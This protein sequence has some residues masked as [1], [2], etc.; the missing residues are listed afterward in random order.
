LAG[1]LALPALIG[2][3]G[4]NTSL[5]RPA[6]TMADGSVVFD[7]IQGEDPEV[8]TPTEPI[9]LDILKPNRATVP[10]DTMMRG[11]DRIASLTY[12]FQDFERTREPSSRRKFVF[13][14][15]TLG[16]V[17]EMQTWF[18]G[19]KGRLTT[20]YMPT[21]QK[22]FTVLSGLGSETLVVENID[23]TNNGFLLSGRHVIGLINAAGDITKA[24]ITEAS[25]DGDTE[26]LTL[27]VAAPTDTV[28]V[29]FLLYVRLESDTFEVIWQNAAGLA[30]IQLGMIECPAELAP[31][32]E[33]FIPG[34]PGAPPTA[35]L[36]PLDEAS[37]TATVP[38]G[39]VDVP[40]FFNI[41]LRDA[42]GQ[43]LRSNGAAVPS[44]NITGANTA[45]AT[46]T[47][48]ENG[49]FRGQYTPT[50]TG[51]DS[52]LLKVNAINIKNTPH[53]SVVGTTPV[54]VPGAMPFGFWSFSTFDESMEYLPNITCVLHNIQPGTA[55]DY[56][57]SAAA[58]GC[59]M[60]FNHPR[61][62]VKD[63]SGQFSLARFKD[64]CDDLDA[65]GTFTSHVSSG[66][67]FVHM[68]IDDMGAKH[69][70]G[71][72]PPKSIISSASAYSHSL[73]PNIK[74]MVRKAPQEL[75]GM[76]DIDY[77]ACLYTILRGNIDAYME[78]NERAARIIGCNIMGGI[79]VVNGGD[80]SSGVPGTGE[81]DSFAAMSA[82][83]IT[84]YGKRV[85]SSS[86]CKFFTMFRFHNNT[87]H[88]VTY[89][90]TIAIKNAIEDLGDFCAG[91]VR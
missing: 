78:A 34:D 65:N 74:T 56:L 15:E 22:D 24:T 3:F 43:R 37:C 30:E 33:E 85:A 91:E 51:T 44:G 83:E 38:N 7:L 18:D 52:L 26:I 14:T 13:T 59:R 42:N 12:T 20:F 81:R 5:S 72:E 8:E 53:I 86:L 60:I 49:S 4:D 61:D 6:N 45:T 16:E 62:R 88:L 77:A 17:G 90:N 2:Y 35:P 82:A 75:I 28:L 27:D 64:A 39:E 63:S 9:V 25:I 68:I 1:T 58:H 11:V 79:H 66:T 40:T 32:E 84:R 29:C 89:F 36:G 21:Y 47:N 76:T 50:A 69:W 19:L 73:W 57:D 55:D 70:G 10:E 48:L 54:I 87:P 80:G 23:Y 31:T 71:V 46:F 41:I 67:P